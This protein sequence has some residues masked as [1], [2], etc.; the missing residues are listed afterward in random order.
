V[1]PRWGE[2]ADLMAPHALARV[3]VFDDVHLAMAFAAAG[4]GFALKQL[5]RSLEEQ[6]EGE[7]PQARMT[8][9]VGLPAA[10][11]MAA[12]AHGAHAA[13]VDQL[14]SLRPHARLMTGSHAQRDVLELTLVEA[15]V[16]DGQLGLARGLLEARLRRKPASPQILRGLARC[17]RRLAS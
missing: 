9:L 2:L 11:A 6:A 5:L 17:G 12:F 4:R 15:A 14:V 16:R 3:H 10:R 7:G 13:A 8:R 1:G